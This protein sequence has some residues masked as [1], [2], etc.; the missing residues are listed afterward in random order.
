MGRKRVA[1]RC[2]GKLVDDHRFQVVG[3]ITDNHLERSVTADVA[4]EAGLSL[5]DFD[6][7]RRAV[8][9][10]RLVYDLGLS[11]LY[12]R[13]LK[14]CFLAHPKYGTINFHP[15][16]LPDYKGVGGYNLAILNGLSEWAVSAHFIDEGIDT[17]PL[18]RKNSFPIDTEL[19]TALSLEQ[20]SQEQL[21]V[22]FGQVIDMVAA[23]PT[24]LPA[25]ET[26]GGMHLSRAELERMKLVDP[27]VDDVDRKVR[28]FWFPPYDGA[29]VE[30]SGQRFTLV[31]RAI[32][33]SLADPDASSLF[34]S[35][36]KTASC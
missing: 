31:N 6:G 29:Y 24:N 18:V 25:A 33:E 13:R 35:P 30:I 5:Y 7:A 22:L 8:D 34:S 23:S 19:E 12:W 3:V 1:A 32:L 10:G 15:A 26:S 36:S 20:K 17:G 21:E 28:A 11:M 2:L 16:P 4:A 9:E 14:N 27:D